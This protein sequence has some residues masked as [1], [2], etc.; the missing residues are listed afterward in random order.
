MS[1]RMVR[2][3]LGD[4]DA[5]MTPTPA[6][7]ERTF[8]FSGGTFRLK[9]CDR[10]ADRFLETMLTWGP[11]IG[12]LVEE[13][14]QTFRRP[15]RETQPASRGTVVWSY[16]A[17]PEVVASVV[18][19]SADDEEEFPIVVRP[20]ARADEDL[21]AG[22]EAWSFSE[23]AKERL[24]ERGFTKAEALWCAMHPDQTKPSP[25]EKYPGC[26]VHI[27]GPVR[28]VVNPKINSIVTVT[29]TNLEQ[30]RVSA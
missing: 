18:D 8:T 3:T 24:I 13:Q 29:Y 21:P 14:S 6:V 16:L 7:E 10:C 5:C 4:C 25:S 12:T 30:E 20:R 15:T 19:E 2:K 1:R 9:L 11:R 22:H 26:V 27:R 28:V 17:V 23:H